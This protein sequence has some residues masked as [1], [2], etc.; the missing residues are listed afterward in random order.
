MYKNSPTHRKCQAQLAL[1][2]LGL[3]L[4]RGGSK[5]I[6]RKNIKLMHG[7]PLIAY[8][9]IEALRSSYI[10]RLAISTDDRNIA[11]VAEEYGAEVPF[12]RPAEL[13]EDHVP[14][15]PVC[16]HCLRWFED[17]E[18]YQPEI[19]V[20]LRPTAPLRTVK[21]IDMC[22]E[23]L[24]ESPGADSVRTVCLAPQHP[25][26][27]WQIDSGVLLPFIPETVYGIDEPYNRP[28]QSLP[29]AYIQN[30]SVDVVRTSV[31]L[32][33]SMTGL[34]LK[35]VVMDESESVNVDSP[36]DWAI[37]EIEMSRRLKT[38]EQSE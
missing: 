4:A 5:G 33:G 32:N 23:V 18:G 14:D 27:M 7:K 1:E 3:I 21:H 11:S 15:L 22:I 13:A 8:T 6:P 12:V 34:H 20:H 28:R 2:I 17:N 19:V 29:T 30:G 38:E 31:I 24:M 9:I 26:K 16:Q 35:G 36:T 25:L 10:S 37:A